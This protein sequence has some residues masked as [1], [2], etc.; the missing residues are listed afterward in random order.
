MPG[1]EQ[2]SPRGMSLPSQPR[3]EEKPNCEEDS[4]VKLWTIA[5]SLSPD[6][7]LKRTSAAVKAVLSSFAPAHTVFLKDKATCHAAKAGH[8]ALLRFYGAK[9]QG[10]SVSVHADRVGA[11]LPQARTQFW[12]ETAQRVR[13]RLFAPSSTGQILTSA[14]VGDPVSSLTALH[15][16]P[17][18]RRFPLKDAIDS[19]LDGAELFRLAPSG[20]P[21]DYA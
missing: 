11:V 4:Q 17:L 20:S 18:G 19:S 1:D 6:T 5:E 9:L 16:L 14:T 10:K 8:L 7:N 13:A 2:I 3:I 12:R 21:L 15:I